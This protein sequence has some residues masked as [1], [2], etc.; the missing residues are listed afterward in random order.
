VTRPPEEPEPT[1]EM[2]Q[3]P[4]GPA[5]RPLV[6][7]PTEQVGMP[8]VQPVPTTPL[9]PVVNARHRRTAILVTALVLLVLAV[10]A[11]AVLIWR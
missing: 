6:D 1:D 7:L 8:A 5:E 11:A 9:A 4:P 3:A 10:M 2:R